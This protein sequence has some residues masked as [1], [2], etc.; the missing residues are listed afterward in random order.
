MKVYYTPTTVEAKKNRAGALKHIQAMVDYIAAAIDE[1]LAGYLSGGDLAGYVEKYDAFDGAKYGTPSGYL[2]TVEGGNQCVVFDAI[3]YKISF[4]GYEVIESAAVA[5]ESDVPRAWDRVVNVISN[6]GSDY[7]VKVGDYTTAIGEA[8]AGSLGSEAPAAMET[9][10]YGEEMHP[11]RQHVPSDIT[12]QSAMKRLYDAAKEL[13]A[14][15]DTVNF[16]D[17]EEK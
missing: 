2:V 15:F 4:A 12:R 10:P 5:N 9:D 17:D 8:I 1:A 11:S 13:V 7:D 16:K 6:G 14:A 3:Q